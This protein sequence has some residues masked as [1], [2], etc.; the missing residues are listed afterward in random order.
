MRWP[1]FSWAALVCLVACSSD[2]AD[3]DGTDSRAADGGDV[4][5][6][7]DTPTSDSEV[8][9][10]T[11][12]DTP[13]DLNADAEDGPSD[14]ELSAF[15]GEEFAE[16]EARIDSAID[17]LTLSEKAAL[18]HGNF[19]LPTDG[20]WQTDGN[21]ALGFEGFHMLDGPRGLSRF[22]QRQGTAFPVAMARGATWDPEL[23]Y[24]VGRMIGAELRL[25]GADTLLAPTVNILRHP[26]WGRAQ[27][28]YG[29]D[30]LHVGVMG[31]A[32]VRGAQNHVMAVV[33]HFAANSIED[34]RLEVNVN[35]S[36]R[37][38][39]EIYLPHFERIV[40][41]GVAG[42]MSSYNQINGDWGSE[43]VFLLN[44]VLRDE[45]GFLGFVVSD[46]TWGT[47]NTVPALTAGLDVEMQFSQVYGLP[48]VDA[49]EAGEVSEE[50]VD[51][52]V[53]RILR[54]HW[55]FES[56]TQASDLTEFEGEAALQLAREA[57]E[58]SMVL[59]ENRESA[60]P[61][62][63]TTEPTIVVV[64]SLAA[65][66]NTGDRGSSHVE[67]SSVVTMLAG[68]QTASGDA[69]VTHLRGDLSD[70]ESLAAVEAADV[71]IAI[72][73]Y[74]EDEEGEGQ[75]AAGDRDSLSLPEDDIAVL[76]I[77]S[78]LNARV[79]AVVIGG[80]S[81]ITD[82]WGDEVE[83]IVAAWYAGAAGGDALAALLFGEQNFQGR[84][85]I[86]FA[87][88]DEDLPEFDNT[89][90]EVEYGYFHGYRHLEREGSG[91]LYPFGYGLSYTEFDYSGLVAQ[92]G[93][94]S[95]VATVDVRNS[96]AMT[97]VE[98]VQ[99]YVAAPGISIVRAA[100]DLRAFSQIEL[101]PAESGTVRLEI[102]LRDFRYFDEDS[103]DWALETGEYRLQV[104]ELEAV[105]TL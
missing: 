42:V 3:P 34:T 63:R 95:V 55:C 73:G 11:A 1:L 26:R 25:H 66:A 89:S 68:L 12:T 100:R 90:M 36:E 43:S 86:S 30:P 88:S 67:S 5:H 41:G 72:V 17:A 50:L 31:E 22:S 75:I 57:A 62:D 51:R 64:G 20:T 59:L 14:D 99:F 8:D 33:K 98:T 35:A 10:D 29:E 24:E 78:E 40:R 81:F 38:L 76:Q 13:E 44:D 92:P 2:G 104:G 93:A 96:G 54:S 69:T 56:T 32:F 65:E 45:W 97:G 58:Q 80:S 94:T 87:R 47:H 105:F 4:P 9:V 85:P 101:A 82:G 84:L 7:P 71:V 6:V 28:T 102:P 91:P 16:I 37:T 70:G 27:E 19:P 83:A 103:G 46:F 61:I 53:R 48:V 49:V 52:A 21:E 77:A 18:M 74:S 23:E 15:C 39:R 60:L 79:V